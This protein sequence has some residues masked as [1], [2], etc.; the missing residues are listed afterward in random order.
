VITVSLNYTRSAKEKHAENVVI[1]KSEQMARLY[2]DNW[3]R[4]K[5]HS[6]VLEPRY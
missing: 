3:N 6:E 2:R 4:H 5:E 1:V